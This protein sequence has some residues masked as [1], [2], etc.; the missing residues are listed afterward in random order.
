MKVFQNLFYCRTVWNVVDIIVA[1]GLIIS[2]FGPKQFSQK[3][4]IIMPIPHK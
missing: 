4:E 2:V 1:V 3:V